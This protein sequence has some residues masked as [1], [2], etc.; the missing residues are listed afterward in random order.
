ML[1]AIVVPL[2]LAGDGGSRQVVAYEL[3]TTETRAS[4]GQN[5]SIDYVNPGDPEGKPP[6]VRRVVT[7]LPKG[8]RFN[9][10]APKQ[11]PASDA[12]L[13]AQGAAACPAGSKLTDG[14]ITLD[15]GV[16]GPA[17]ITTV[18]VTFFNNER[19]LIYLNTIRGS[20]TRVVVRGTV[21]RRKIITESPFLPGTPPDGAAIDTV[22]ANDPP[23]TTKRGNYITT[24]RR[25]PTRGFWLMRVRFTYDDGVTQVS[26]DRAACDAA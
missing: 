14:V 26:R 4:S 19:E 1:L 15:S 13:M 6:A 5:L 16:P 24:P 10:N 22:V 8:A 23:I 12:E 7:V 9:T 18:D 17:R 2:A 11:C 25:C 3:T 21:R 20:E